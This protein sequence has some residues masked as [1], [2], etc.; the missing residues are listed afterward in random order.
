MWPAK[1]FPAAREHFDETSRPT[2]EVFSPSYLREAMSKAEIPIE[3]RAYHTGIIQTYSTSLSFVSAFQGSAV[4]Q[5]L[6]NNNNISR[7]PLQ[8]YQKLSLPYS[9]VVGTM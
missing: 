5:W 7:G 1:E 2:L 4:H 3:P 8:L 9:T 6:C